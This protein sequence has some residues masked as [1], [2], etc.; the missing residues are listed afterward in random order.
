MGN[1]TV[2]TSLVSEESHQYLTRN[3]A[4]GTLYVTTER[5]LFVPINAS[6]T[7]PA[8]FDILIS[9]I[10]TMKA[11]QSD[12]GQWYFLCYEGSY[13][14]TIPFKNHTRARSFLKL[15]ANIRFEQMVRRSLP[16]KYTL[17]CGGARPCG[18]V[19]A[20][21]SRDVYSVMCGAC[22]GADN[23]DWAGEDERLP[24][25]SESEEA[26]RQHLITLGL[27]TED[28]PFDRQNSTFD[29]ISMLA[30]ACSP[31]NRDLATAA[32][33]SAQPH[34]RRNSAPEPPLVAGTRTP[35]ARR[36]SVPQPRAAT[37]QRRP[38]VY[39]A[40]EHVYTVPLVWI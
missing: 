28:T 11:I 31:P 21:T 16:P 29:V 2:S 15:I 1:P 13:L 37:L 24:T 8:Q 25:Y 14:C 19:A 36:A 23:V 20:A 4:P 9:D 22:A 26:V 5:L 40:E 6:S 39:A 32:A 17:P 27:L 3:C 34:P 7:T 12:A 38:G 33:T 30:Q 35:G 10:D 18:C